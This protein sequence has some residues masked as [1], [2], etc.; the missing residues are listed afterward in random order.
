M[1]LFEEEMKKFLPGIYYCS[2][3]FSRSNL[4]PMKVWRKYLMKTATTSFRNKR[5]ISDTDRSRGPLGGAFL[6]GKTLGASAAFGG[7]KGDLRN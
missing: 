1:F 6:A 2:M 7:E 5:T 4:F 3:P